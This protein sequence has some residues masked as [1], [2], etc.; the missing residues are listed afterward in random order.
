MAIDK[1]IRLL[2]F[3]VLIALSA[4]A[5]NGQEVTASTGDAQPGNG[6]AVTAPRPKTF[7][8]MPPKPPKVTCNGGSLTISAE[9]STLG[10]VLAAVHACSGVHIDMPEGSVSKRT[11]EELGPGPVR[12]VLESL[13]SGTDFN[14]VI[15]SSSSNPQKVETVLLML[16]TDEKGAAAA[17][18]TDIAMTPAR[19]AWQLTQKNGRATA[20][21]SAQS[22]QMTADSS[23]SPDADDAVTPTA[24]NQGTDATQ[25]ANAAATAEIAANPPVASTGDV[26]S[27]ANQNKGTGDKITDMQQLF[28][29][30]RQMIESQNAPP[31]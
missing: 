25:A 9:N 10:S 19:R 15:G 30:R 2:S 28:E 13:L 22:R 21:S 26:S 31:K 7:A 6:P 4:P 1:T 23:A 8:E 27:D 12:E 18:S 14:Y 5:S 29:Q 24:D 11:Y 20:V 16:R 17:I 3:G